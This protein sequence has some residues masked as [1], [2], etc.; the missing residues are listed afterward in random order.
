MSKIRQRQSSSTECGLKS[1]SDNLCELYVLNGLKFDVAQIPTTTVNG[2]PNICEILSAN[3]AHNCAAQYNKRESEA[4]KQ[5]NTEEIQDPRSANHSTRKSC[6]LAAELGAPVYKRPSCSLCISRKETE[7]RFHHKSSVTYNSAWMMPSIPHQSQCWP[8]QP[9]DRNAWPH[10]AQ[11]N[12]LYKGK[13]NAHS[14][15]L[16]APTHPPPSHNFLPLS[17]RGPTGRA[18]SARDALGFSDPPPRLGVD[19]LET[20][21]SGVR[22]ARSA[23][24]YLQSPWP[25]CGT[26]GGCSSVAESETREA[27]AWSLTPMRVW[28]RS[29]L[30]LTTLLLGIGG[31]HSIL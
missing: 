23:G 16:I 13:L 21:R 15:F 9:A 10:F 11:V 17:S 14:H 26:S 22:P 18:R 6:G 28:G 31:L 8:R 3:S 2:I 30:R 12:G 7:N 4:L 27:E 1:L 5:R 20:V 29:D 24:V 25:L 19:A